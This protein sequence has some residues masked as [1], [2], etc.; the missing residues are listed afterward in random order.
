MYDERLPAA[1]RLYGFRKKANWE[2]HVNE[3]FISYVDKRARTNA[4]PCPDPECST[5]Y[6][7]DQQL[8]YHLQD[9]HSYPPRKDRPK[10]KP[11]QDIFVDGTYTLARIKRRRTGTVEEVSN[12][13]L[14]SAAGTK[15]VVES[16]W[17]ALS[18]PTPYSSSEA[19]ASPST[20]NTPLS[21]FDVDT[22]HKACRSATAISS[23]SL[24]FK[25]TYRIFAPLFAVIYKSRG[26]RGGIIPSRGRN[27]T[28][29]PPRYASQSSEKHQRKYL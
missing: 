10:T 29:N 22:L 1:R 21:I 9:V 11:K 19:S 14:A 5:I 25:R 17:P 4:I 20:A 23:P 13:K 6:E 12:S 28:T 3:C 24:S 18:L 27:T 2:T 16:Y 15:S 7:T 8:W 26:Y